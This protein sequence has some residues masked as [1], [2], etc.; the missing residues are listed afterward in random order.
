MGVLLRQ[1]HLH[2]PFWTHVCWIPEKYAIVGK[3]L[4]VKMYDGWQDGW[5]VMRVG[6]V[7]L[8]EEEL[9]VRKDDHSHQRE[10]SD[11]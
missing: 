9:A 4:R 6:S 2:Q 5:V 8:T 10:V 11:I 3:V 7:S 1:V